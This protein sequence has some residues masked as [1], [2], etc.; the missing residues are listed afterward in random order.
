MTNEQYIRLRL[1]DREKLAGIITEDQY[2]QKLQEYQEADKLAI[3]AENIVD[4]INNDKNISD[5]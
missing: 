1:L 3:Q 2:I 5:E 4:Q